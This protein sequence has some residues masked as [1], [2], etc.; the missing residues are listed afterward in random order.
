MPIISRGFADKRDPSLI[1]GQHLPSEGDPQ[2][3]YGR[4]IN[5]P[6]LGYLSMRRILP[7]KR[8]LTLGEYLDTIEPILSR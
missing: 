1:Q 5:L 4:N 6:Y 2:R 7:L 3:L 8:A